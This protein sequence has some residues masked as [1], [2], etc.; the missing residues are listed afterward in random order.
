VAGP[1][2]AL[3][4]ASELLDLDPGLEAG[5]V[6]LLEGRREEDVDA[7]L[8]REARVAVLV[9]RITGEVLA[10][11]ELGGVD[12][13]ARNDLVV[14]LACGAEEGEVAFVEG[15]HRGDEPDRAGR[16]GAEVAQLG[17]GADDDHRAVA[18]ARTS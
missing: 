5:R 17:R 1:V 13:Q 16:G 18:S 14:L 9:P 7:V 11:D 3:E 8:L 4:D 15:A 2:L 12:E 10:G 6:H